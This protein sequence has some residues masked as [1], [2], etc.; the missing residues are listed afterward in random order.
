MRQSKKIEEIC[1]IFN[2]H[3]DPDLDYLSSVL[4][5]LKGRDIN[6]SLG[7]LRPQANFCIILGGDGTMLRVA[8]KAAVLNIPMLGI[9]LG[10]L[11]FLTDV[12]KQ[13]G[14]TALEKVLQG[15]Y[16]EDKRLMLETDFS[17]G[18]NIALNEICVGSTG[19]LKTFSVYVNDQ[20]MDVI[21]A[22]GIVVATPT[23]ST[24]YNL[25][26]G[27]PI[28][29]PGGHMMVITPICP[30]SLS[31]RPWVISADDEVRIITRQDSPLYLDGENLG[32]IKSGDSVLVKK[33]PHR[34]TIIKTA[35]IHFYAV[36]RKKKI[37]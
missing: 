34:A 12:D 6:V 19:Q 13:F 25:S 28:L 37:L 16:I 8:H 17:S 36:L 9:N 4:D 3:K 24:A 20:H 31:S 1:I 10:N 30:H 7:N 2:V 15:D 27:G 32:I 22:D 14:I 26:A 35:P 5:F 33:S 29:V 18:Y 23:G 21:R 11:G